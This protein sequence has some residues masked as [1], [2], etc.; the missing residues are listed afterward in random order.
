MVIYTDFDYLR[1]PFGDATIIRFP[2]IPNCESE[3]SAAPVLRGNIKPRPSYGG[4]LVI[5]PGPFI[6]I[7]VKT[8]EIC[9]VVC[10]SADVSMSIKFVISG[11]V[12]AM[13]ILVLKNVYEAAHFLQYLFPAGIGHVQN[14]GQPC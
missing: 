3:H 8:S 14:P 7:H 1:H 2:Y 11:G 9:S 12:P 13:D 6:P 10:Y 5:K 4:Y